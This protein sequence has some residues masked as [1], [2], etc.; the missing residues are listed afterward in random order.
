MP[1]MSDTPATNPTMIAALAVVVCRE[2]YALVG[3]AVGTWQ[4]V[5]DVQA[6][7]EITEAA[8]QEALYHAV[9]QGWVEAIGTPMVS[10]MLREPGRALFAGQMTLPKPPLRVV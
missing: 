3:G 7:L 8:V 4:A 1:T 5:C 9:G 2:V 6:R 10:V